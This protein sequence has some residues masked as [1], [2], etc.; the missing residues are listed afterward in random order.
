VNKE[1]FISIIE[2]YLPERSAEPVALWVLN[3]NL[4]IIIK[5]DRKTKLGDFRAKRPNEHQHTITINSGLNIYEFLIT[6]VHEFAH[7]EV[8]EEFGRKVKPHGIEWQNTYRGLMIEYFEL[9]IFP[10][11]L[12]IVLL[13][14]LRNPKASSH[15]DLNLVR[16]LA[17]YDGDSES[18]EVYLEDLH[19][20]DSFF[21]NGRIFTK[22]EKRR[23]RYMCTELSTKRKFTVSALA[24]VLKYE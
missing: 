24:K 10:K 17:K 5:N 20:G 14:H 6:L 7:L 21:I 16:Q 19:I 23:T 9:N 18:K 15:G 13:K 11:A 4:R 22:G 1:K 3:K 2:K 12:A 8:Y